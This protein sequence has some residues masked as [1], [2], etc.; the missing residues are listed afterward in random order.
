MAEYLD[1]LQNYDAA[2]KAFLATGIYDPRWDSDL[3]NFILQT[4]KVSFDQIRAQNLRA[5][6]VLSLMAVLNRQAGFEK[7]LYKETES[8][9][10]LVTAIGVLKVFSLIKADS[11]SRTFSMHRLVQLATQR[12]LEL[13]GTIDEWQEMALVE[14][15]S[16]HQWFWQPGFLVW[17]FPA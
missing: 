12:W 9:I 5:A 8:R 14:V 1:I 6:E 15:S 2:V 10:D 13:E 7:P 11:G 3:S 16:L 4:W 17:E